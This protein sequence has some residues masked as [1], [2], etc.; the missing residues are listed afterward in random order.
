MNQK[1]SIITINYNNL[2]GLQST[3]ESILRLDYQNFEW[4]IIDGGSTDG[5]KVF[6]EQMDERLSFW[7]SEN[8][9]G[10]Y[11][12]MNKGISHAKGEYVIFMNSGD[13][14]YSETVLSQVFANLK[15]SPD[16]IYGNALYIFE[17]HEELKSVPETIDFRFIY[18][19]TIFHQASFIKRELLV[20]NG[21][22]DI[23]LKIVSDWK[24]WLIF[25][26]QNRVFVYTPHV[27][28]RFDAYGISTGHD[29]N[30][31]KERNI[32]FQ[33]ILPPGIITMMEEVYAYEGIIPYQKYL[34]YKIAE[35]RFVKRILNGFIKFIKIF[36]KYGEW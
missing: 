26:L 13:S 2:K 36:V 4:I 23:N 15:N 20:E 31:N 7:C 14:F 30:V 32:V 18:E 8:D 6:I 28:C 1:V 5:S 22:Y 3:A 34:F 19:Y 29:D 25:I 21:G 10:V 16:V 33:E 24:I 27:I 17:D 11:D 9:K 35:I 12:A